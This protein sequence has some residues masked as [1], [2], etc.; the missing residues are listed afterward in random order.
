MT[1]PSPPPA[2]K[3]LGQH[4][5]IDPNIVRKIL[6]EA[7]V[8]SEETVFEI[9]PGRG[10]LTRPLCQVASHV[11]AVEF[12]KK[13][14]DYLISICSPANLD[15]RIGDAL[16]FPFHALP[17]NTVVVANLPY[18]ISTPLLFKLLEHRSH[19]SLLVLMLQLEVAKR[20]TAKPGSRNYGTLSVLSQYYA[21]ARLAFKV[22]A[23]CFRPMPDVES[24]VVTLNLHPRKNS[25]PAF[26]ED[27]I[28]IVRSAFAHRRKTLLNSFRDS[29][30]SLE[31]IQESLTT[32][33]ID[34]KRRAETITL[35][36]F[37]D[38]THAIR[39]YTL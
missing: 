34:S 29:G 17:L 20:L 38:L 4:F 12:D 22:P 15:L 8:G 1:V 33:G 21:S 10:I 32:V 28:E 39:R 19:I 16:A 31:T 26:D 18:Y 37:V 27:F 5:L 2:L 30:F 36:E 9:G 23:T 7:A 13:L 14:A 3:Q 25:D 35:L 6:N 24:S 11:I